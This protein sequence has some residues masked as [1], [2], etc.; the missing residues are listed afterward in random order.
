MLPDLSAPPTAGSGVVVSAESEEKLEVLQ[1]TPHGML[2]RQIMAGLALKSGLAS[3]ISPK[4]DSLDKAMPVNPGK[5][6]V[7]FILVGKKT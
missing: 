4:Q 3:R 2:P 6:S 1:A 5:S 7:V